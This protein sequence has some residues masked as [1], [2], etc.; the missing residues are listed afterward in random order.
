LLPFFISDYIGLVL[1]ICLGYIDI[2]SILFQEIYIIMSTS[3]NQWF[4]KWGY[5]AIAIAVILGLWLSKS[6]ERENQNNVN[7]EVFVFFE[8]VKSDCKAES[9][10]NQSKQCQEIFKFQKECKQLSSQCNSLSYYQHLE[11]LGFQLPQYY[12][13]GF[14]PK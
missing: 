5:I 6:A 9:F 2:K 11:S 1:R 8:K 14:S 4:W 7:P 3:I 13:H 12:Q 10:E